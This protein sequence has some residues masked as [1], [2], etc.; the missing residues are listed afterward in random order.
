MSDMH[1]LPIG[2]AR[3]VT[4]EEIA[5]RAP[6]DGRELGRVPKAGPEEVDQAVAAARAARDEHPLLAWERAEILD[7]ASRR[8]KE[9]QED[10]AQ[11]IATEAAK[12]IKTARVEA[13]RAVGTFAFA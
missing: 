7:N 9:R 8:I 4:G 12:P 3:I 13:A 2:N 1:P 5:I 11:S 10:L 6:F